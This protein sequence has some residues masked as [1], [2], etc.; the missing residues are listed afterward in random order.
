[1]DVPLVTPPSDI[2]AV[3][4]TER[5]PQSFLNQVRHDVCAYVVT[6][7][8]ELGPKVP[9]AQHDQIGWHLRKKMKKRGAATFAHMGNALEASVAAVE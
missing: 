8:V 9:Q 4:L 1:M 2:A 7:S 6:G 5:Q 3:A